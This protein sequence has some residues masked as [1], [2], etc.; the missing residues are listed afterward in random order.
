[1][2]LHRVQVTQGAPHSHSHLAALGPFYN[3][4]K[5]CVYTYHA[6]KGFCTA[7][8]WQLCTSDSAKETLVVTVVHDG[9]AGPD[10]AQQS[11]Y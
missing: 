10:R 11:C 7:C 4:G 1:M 6:D 9:A 8:H 3:G 5:Q 2:G